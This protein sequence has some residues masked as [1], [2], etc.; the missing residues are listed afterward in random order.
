[1]RTRAKHAVCIASSAGGIPI[2][3]RVLAE[4]PSSV[5]AAILVCQHTS[6]SSQ[7][8]A[9][10]QPHTLLPVKWAE[11][12][13]LTSEGE[14]YIV[15]PSK[16]LRIQNDGQSRVSEIEDSGHSQHSADVLF[17]STATHFGT[18]CIAV[19][20]SGSGTD[21]A[22]GAQ[23]INS[24]GGT[25]IVQDERT[26]QFLQMPKAAIETRAVRFILAESDIAGRIIALLAPGH[27]RDGG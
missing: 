24:A 2:L 3:I 14:V 26:C 15:P 27:H 12:D 23:K 17:E 20:L 9:V 10:L 16:Y 8:P 1:M 25:V 21:G 6:K 13:E 19:I 4:L 18:C 5:P 11:D 7:L 22:V